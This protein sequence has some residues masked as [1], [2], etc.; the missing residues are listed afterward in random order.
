MKIQTQCIPC[1]LKRIIFEVEESTKDTNLKTRAIRRACEI[2]SEL[3]DPAKCSAT[4]AT[5]LHKLVYKILGNNDP[6]KELKQKSNEVALSLTPQVEK[7]IEESNDPLKMSMKCSI[8]GNSMD[9]GIEGAC[10]HPDIFNEVFAKTISDR[11]GH[12]DTEE[13]KDLLKKSKNVLLFTDNCGEIVFD[14]I[15]CRELKKYNPDV[16]LTIVVKG[17]PV[18]SDATLEDVEEL[19]FKDVV[20][21]ILTTGCFAVGVDFEKIPSNLKVALNQTDLIICKGMANYESFSEANYSPIVYLLRT[22]CNVIANSMN[23]PLN[24][25]AVKLYK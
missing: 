21:E 6:Y 3:Y 17:E 20:D 19:K 25:N 16:N 15:L 8:A 22:K 2:L 7:L 18:L 5:K 11:F 9:F 13:F 23:L 14:K 24:I 1:L 10:S 4:I 12:D